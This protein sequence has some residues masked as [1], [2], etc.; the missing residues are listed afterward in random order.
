[1]QNQ[2]SL[3]FSLSC[4]LWLK[5]SVDIDEKE[6]RWLLGTPWFFLHMI[7][8][9]ARSRGLLGLATLQPSPNEADYMEVCYAEDALAARV[10]R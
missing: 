9:T 1:M 2:I 3:W 6:K 4:N 8:G 5:V 10:S 7:D